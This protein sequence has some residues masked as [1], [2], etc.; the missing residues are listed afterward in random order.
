MKGATI[1]IEVDQ[2][3]V[4]AV[5]LRHPVLHFTDQLEVCD[6]ILMAQPFICSYQNC[7]QNTAV[8]RTE[9]GSELGPEQIGSK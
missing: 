3:R 8:L 4:S 5:H 6:F 9:K 7:E 1:I 2:I